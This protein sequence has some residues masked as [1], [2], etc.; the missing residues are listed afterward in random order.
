MHKKLAE[1][2]LFCR[3]NCNEVDAGLLELLGVVNKIGEGFSWTLLKRLDEHEEL[4]SDQNLLFMMECNRKLSMAL[5][6]LNE[7]FMPLV[8]NKTGVDLISHAVYNCGSNFK[9][10]NYAGFYSAILERDGE[11]ISVA[12]LRF[13]GRNLAEMPFIGTRPMH[14]RQG[15][16]RRLLKAIENLLASLH[17]EKLIIPATAELLETWMT[18]FSFKPLEQSHKDEIRNLSL[19]VFPQA[20]LLQKSMPPKGKDDRGY[21]LAGAV[22]APRAAA[23]GIG[24][25]DLQNYVGKQTNT[26]SCDVGP[27][28][29]SE[30]CRDGGKHSA[31]QSNFS[32][33]ADSCGGGLHLGSS[34]KYVPE[35]SYPAQYTPTSSCCG[36]PSTL[37]E[38]GSQFSSFDRALDRSY[39]DKEAAGGADAPVARRSQTAGMEKN[40]GDSVCCSLAAGYASPFQ[41]TSS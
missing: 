2:L 1:S 33:A 35:A 8:D 39:G 7:C 19:V 14:R 37:R 30:S 22:V 10:L 29:N 12:S 6:V 31:P 4:N 34:Y 40:I 20:F 3:K 13:H 38:T 17:V 25:D 11:I 24:M 18:S 23:P 16:C 32:S 26:E 41:W 36:A 27:R 5:S 28:R 15:M 21:D 9:R